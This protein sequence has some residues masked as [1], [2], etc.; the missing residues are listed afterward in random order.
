MDTTDDEVEKAPRGESP[1]GAQPIGDTEKMSGTF[2]PSAESFDENSEPSRPFITDRPLIAP[3]PRAFIPRAKGYEVRWPPMG[4]WDVLQFDFHGPNGAFHTRQIRNGGLITDFDFVLGQHE[5]HYRKWSDGRWRDWYNSTPFFAADPPTIAT[6]SGTIFDTKYPTIR[7][8]GLPWATFQLWLHQG[9]A[10][11][12][13]VS[14]GASGEWSLTATTPLEEGPHQ[15]VV[16]QTH[17]DWTGT[18]WATPISIT[19][20]EKQVEPVIGSPKAGEVIREPKPQV[21]GRG[22]PRAEIA[23]YEYE[24]DSASYGSTNVR[25]DGGWD[26]TLTRVLPERSFVMVARQTF[27]N[28]TK[29]S[30]PVPTTVRTEPPVI[31]DPENKSVQDSSFRVSGTGGET[32]AIIRIYLDRWETMVGESQPMTG[33]IWYAPVVLSP[34]SVSVV[35]KEVL[36]GQESPWRSE[37]RLFKIRPAKL[38]VTVTPLPNDTVKFSGAGVTG[39]TVEITKF[40]GP[41][42]QTVPPVPVVDGQW[43]VTVTNWSLGEY[44]MSAFQKVSDNAGDWIP[45]EPTLF[46]FTWEVPTPTDVTCRVANYT[47]TISGKGY[48]EA[49]VVLLNDG[50]ATAALP[51]TTVMNGVWTSTALTPWGPTLERNVNIRQ[52]LNGQWSK[53]WVVFKVSIPPLAP[54]ITSIV[55]NELSPIITGKCWAGSGVVLNLLYSDSSTVHNPT[56]TNGSWTFRRTNPFAHDVRH[57][58]TVTQ[59]VASQTSDPASGTFTIPL[60]KLV[61]T[62]PEPG[63]DEEVGPDLVV[64]GSNGVKGATV[65]IR[66]AQNGPILGS[67][68]LSDDGPWSVPF[69]K[70]PE[71]RRYSIDATQSNSVVESERSEVCVFRVVL[72]PPTFEVPQPG[73]DL[74]RTSK[75]SGQGMSGGRVSVWRQGSPV[76][77]LRDIPVDEAGRWEGPVMLFSVGEIILRTT[78][79]FEQQTSEDSPPLTCN[80]VPNAPDMESPATNEFVQNE[81]VCSGFGYTDTTGDTV[82]VAL[83]DAP[84]TVLGSTQVLADRTWSMRITLDRPGGNH[85]LIAVQSRN[86]FNSAPSSERLIRFGSFQ[87]EF[88]VPTE[89]RWVTDPVAF[90]GKGRDGVGKLVVGL[91][92]DQTLVDDI[93]IAETDWQATSQE[94]LRSGGNW[95]IFQQCL[96]GGTVMSRRVDS[97]RFEVVA[98]KPPSE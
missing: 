20:E 87:P 76:P 3:G 48:N 6:P 34:G 79:T 85:R 37:P 64:E 57:T 45:S 14:I 21:S 19:I 54:D 4:I 78:Q 42:E 9:A 32:G 92:P 7:G 71:F 55:D 47:P 46:S 59:T 67:R 69:D 11:G 83:A 1:G 51:E 40:S 89:G 17:G 66:D 18:I 8:K 39:A 26:F 36:D 13:P 56:V 68:L 16:G 70:P 93:V 24:E 35:A 95:V 77:L 27:N 72:L 53:P 58:V 33:P 82:T 94:A 88:N 25:Q 44:R 31:T 43:Q 2:E 12:N 41:G 52:G 38:A 98:P 84:Q 90:E 28:V 86:G 74:P 65:K 80:V 73:G 49:T 61:I 22:Q 75:I 91:T 96:E 50:G 5:I 15:V 62:S 10:L 97:P 63:K 30:K 60:P 81:V 29:F 23:I